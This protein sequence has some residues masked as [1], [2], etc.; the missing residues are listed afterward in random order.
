LSNFL[1]IINK[2]S[3]KELDSQETFSLL[4]TETPEQIWEK[5]KYKEKIAHKDSYLII[6]VRNDSEYEDHHIPGSIHVPFYSLDDYL[7]NNKKK[8][9]KNTAVVFVCRRGNTSRLAA[10]KAEQVGIKAISLK[11]GDAEWSRL[12]LPRVRADKCV[13]RFDLE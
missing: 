12:N 8:M 5:V 11:G 7:K 13:V 10:Y 3:I 2:P 4:F 6:D 9:I 1:I